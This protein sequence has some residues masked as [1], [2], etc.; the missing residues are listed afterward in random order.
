LESFSA[1]NKGKDVKLSIDGKKLAIGLGKM[2]D[3]D[4]CGHE[5]EPT[6]LERKEKHESDIN[7]V[8]SAKSLIELLNLDKS[9]CTNPDIV[10]TKKA[11]LI[12]ISN[13]SN[14]IKEL[15]EQIVKRE[16]SVRNL[17]KQIEGDWRSCKVAPAISFNKTKILQCHSCIRD[18]LHSIDNLGFLVACINGTEESYIFGQKEVQLS[19]QKNYLCLREIDG[20][21]TET[22]DVEPAHIKQ[23]SHRWHDLRKKGRVSGSTLFKALGLENLKQQ[24]EHF[25]KVMKGIDK[26]V[27]EETRALFEYGTAQEINAVAT[28]VGKVIPVYYPSLVFREDGCNIVDLNHSFAV[29]SGDGS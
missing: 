7:T 5:Q 4:L 17:T 22:S 16:T 10:L 6:L 19:E 9:S 14:R 23:R 18:L 26:P 3:E 15:R 24:Q 8:R 12:T 2:G 21:M 11:L 25:D 20:V 28:L 13:L 29:I 1:I 27:N